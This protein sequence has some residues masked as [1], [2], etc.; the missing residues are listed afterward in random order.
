MVHDR[1]RAT[2]APA[3]GGTFIPVSRSKSLEAD[4]LTRANVLTAALSIQ[5]GGAALRRSVADADIPAIRLLARIVSA[6]AR[7]LES[8]PNLNG[9]FADGIVRYPAINVG[10]AIDLDQGL[11][12][13]VVHNANGLSTELIEERIIELLSR[14]ID[15]S[16]TLDDVSGAGM[17]VS[18]LSMEEVLNFQ[19]LLNDRQAL[20]IGVGGDSSLPGEPLTLTATFDHRLTSGRE[21]SQ[22]LAACRVALG[23][24]S[25]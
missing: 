22:F 2:G 21:V 4:L 10:V 14:Y 19:P 7:A 1:L 15:S 3:D 18:D 9:F 25:H 24:V 13:G 11:K 6:T 5:F 16:L 20:G 23:V 17:T 8:F 12:V